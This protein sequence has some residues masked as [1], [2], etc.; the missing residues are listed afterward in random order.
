MAKRNISN[1]PAT[2]NMPACLNKLAKVWYRIYGAMAQEHFVI[3]ATVITFAWAFVSLPFLLGRSYIPWDS[4]DEFF[5]QVQFI[6]SCIREWQAPWWDP[7]MFGGQPVLGDPQGM[8]FT[9]HALVGALAGGHFNLHIF[10]LTTLAVELFG[11]IALARY[12]RAYSDT[13]TLPILGAIVFIA[14]GVATSRL[15]HVPQIVSYGLLPLQLLALRA[16]CV[17]PTLNQTALLAITLT[18]GVLNLNQVTFLSAFAL[19]PFAG[20]HFYQ[21]PQR[22]RAFRALIIAGGVALLVDS[23][24][25]SAIV[26]FVRLSNRAVMSI[27]QSVSHSFPV[28][29][30]A[31]LFMPGLYGVHTPLN[32]TWSPTDITED[33]LYIG[34]IP[35]VVALLSLFYTR[36]RIP[37]IT[38]LCW[39]SIVFWFVFTLGTNTSMYGFLF[40]HVPGFSGF[41]R[42]AD[43]AYFVNLFLAIL[44]G[45]SRKPNRLCLC[46]LK[47]FIVVAS[48]LLITFAGLQALIMQ[49]AE[50]LNHESDFLKVLWSMVERLALISALLLIFRKID[51]KKT[52]WW[53][54]PFLIVATVV[55]IASAGRTT[56]IFAP[57]VRGNNVA[58]IYSN[59]KYELSLGNQLAQS[60]AFIQANSVAGMNAR[61]RMEAM[62]ALGASMPLAF[63]ILSTQGYSPITLAAY[64]QTVGV[65]NLQSEA[66]RFSVESPDYDS[67]IYRRLSLRYVLIPRSIAE[68][69]EEFGQIGASV[70]KIRADFSESVWA[71]KVP[72][73]GEYEVWEM[74]NA[75]PRATLVETEA[76]EDV[77]KIVSYETVC[78]TVD[79]HTTNPGRMVLGDVY[80][81]GWRACINGRAVKIDKYQNIFRSVQVPA[82]DT[83]VMFKYQPV[84]FLRNDSCN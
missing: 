57:S 81:P 65:Q 54:A 18:A 22:G 73:P 40:H 33:F 68:H 43:G 14:G 48:C 24:V 75:L 42:P 56:A 50:S 77:C 10:D 21:S 76:S 66:K 72:A 6:A 12:I 4:L 15:Q 74:Q 53:G 26:E 38:V 58:R 39:A 32:G 71:H 37:A 62:G 17:L 16:V 46:S 13:R 45:S 36:H 11:G 79:C 60:I 28:F 19:L 52:L 69:A 1:T 30:L 2:Q 20:L 82:G 70:K 3:D 34:I 8:I 78:V 63:R 51:R 80:A 47:T 67:S 7:F 84:P 55:D 5:P 41:K 83:I 9:P 59:F 29:N 61:Y 64:E 23:P 35:F 27:D 31:S 49:Y 44:I 25:L